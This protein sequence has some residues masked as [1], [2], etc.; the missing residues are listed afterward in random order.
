[1][2]LLAAMTLFS[3]QGDAIIEQS[4]PLKGGRGLGTAAYGPT[5]KEGPFLKK[6]TEKE[7]TF[8]SDLQ[9]PKPS[10]MTDEEWAKLQKEMKQEDDKRKATTILDEKYQLP[11]QAGQYVGW[12]GILRGTT[13]DEK[14]GITTL[15][16]EHKYFDGMTD[17]HQLVV[18][19]NGAGDFTAVVG[20]TKASLAPLSLVRVYGK[21]TKDKSGLPSVA[22][23]YVRVWD[24]G[25]FAFMAYGKDKSNPAWLQSRK[26]AK[27]EEYSVHPTPEYYESILGKRP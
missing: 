9:M 5:A 19:I 1:M 3:L 7:V 25:L 8:H 17:L 18:S 4:Q 12:F 27:D 2:M 6:V 24:W 22:A 15:T 10:N 26:P 20:R 21:V 16:L 13:K 11:D 14:T 23:E